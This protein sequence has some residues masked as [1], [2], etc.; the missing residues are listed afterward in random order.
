M[1][2]TRTEKITIDRKALNS[3]H[4]SCDTMPIALRQN[5]DKFNRDVIRLLQ[6]KRLKH[7][8]LVLLETEPE[9]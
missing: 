8:K 3:I 1:K 7:A 2:L 9:K 6:M 5:L 4:V